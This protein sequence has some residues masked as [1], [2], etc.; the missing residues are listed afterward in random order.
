MIQLLE[1]LPWLSPALFGMSALLAG[2]CRTRIWQILAIATTGG[3][4]SIV[5]TGMYAIGASTGTA[6]GAFPPALL[7]AALIAFLGWIIGDF[8][9]R[10]L[11]GEPGQ[12][13]FVI[14]FL[15]TLASVSTVVLSQNLGVLIAAW[16]ASS[17]ALDHLLT[18]YSDRPAALIVAHKKF[19]ASRLAETCLLAAAVLLYRQWDTLN[20]DLL[21]KLASSTAALPPAAAAA[22]VL[23]AIA[24][25]LKSA[26]LPLHGWLIQV[27]EAPTPVSALLHAGVVNLGGYVLIRLAP[28]IS[29][30]PSAQ[31]LLVIVGSLTAVLA[32]LVMMT[33][34][35]I[36]VRLAWSTCSQMGLMLM[37]CGLGLYDLALLHLV[38]HSLYKAHAFLT[39]GEAVQESRRRDLLAAAQGGSRA[40]SI[41][42]PIVS[43]SVT[44]FFVLGSAALLLA[45]LQFP[46]PSWTALVL[47][48]CGLAT[49]L[50]AP[51]HGTLH[52]LR[53]SGLV[54]AATL[55]YF[56]WH[57]LFSARIGVYPTITHPLLAAWVLLC[58]A[59]LYLAQ[60]KSVTGA[61]GALRDRLYHWVYAGFYL[62]ERF[63]RLIFRLWPANLPKSAV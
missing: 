10:Y 20:L 37:E 49:L 13:R 2:L 21:G 59:G 38:A 31:T 17:I 27:M 63:T 4:L 24:V 62:D 30:S 18:F 47:L 12:A 58:F 46:P 28:L 32:G 36:K 16:V 39:S 52:Y 40:R 15:S 14:A 50:W 48:S 29:A 25:M 11:Q 61:S 9:S 7:V 51:S 45:T 5:L 44:A 22:A 1:W 55:L 57:W 33:R 23:I 8:S 6:T 35:T 60:W 34:V 53:R 54:L 19:L 26:Q 3:L 56:G 42:V 43:L 41:L